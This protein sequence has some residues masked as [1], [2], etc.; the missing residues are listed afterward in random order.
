ML[1]EAAVFPPAGHA[2]H[3]DAV[4]LTLERGEKIPKRRTSWDTPASLGR[5]LARATAFST[6]PAE[7]LTQHCA[8]ALE[9]CVDG[10]FRLRCD[11]AVEA[12][13]Y[14][15]V[16]RCGQYEALAHVGCPSL[17]VGADMNHPGATWATRMQDTIHARIDGSTFVPLPGVG[18]LAPI[19]AP[20]LCAR[21]VRD[22]IEREAARP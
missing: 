1:V 10:G 19:E 16:M 12:H 2:L 3:A 13:L 15:E 20:E 14:G 21:I 6:M 17:M 11:P 9:A 8:A 18:H 4:S 5:S 7:Y 22:W